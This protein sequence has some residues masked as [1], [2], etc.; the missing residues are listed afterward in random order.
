MKPLLAFDLD[1]TLIDSGPDLIVA[2]NTTL[3][4]MGL[5][6]LDPELIIA[7]ISEGLRNLLHDLLLKANLSISYEEAERAFLTNYEKV[8]YQKTQVFEGVHEFLSGYDGPIGI[9]TNKNVEPTKKIVQHLGLDKYPW[10]EIFGANSLA[11]KKPSPLPLQ[12]MMHLA[13]R[14]PHSTLMIGDG[15]PDVQSARNA[16]VRSVA[17]GFGYTKREI[18]LQY[19]PVGILEHYHHFPEMLK[20]MVFA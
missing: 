16:G 17:I 11:E 12:T 2:I 19:Q 20:K 13:K 4:E 1:G 18:L 14:G 7:N 10:V 3:Q 5:K 8:M 6:P 15:L 9:I